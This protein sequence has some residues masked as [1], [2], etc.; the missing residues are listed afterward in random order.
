MLLAIL[1]YYPNVHQLIQIDFFMILL[2]YAVAS[3]SKYILSFETS[4]MTPIWA[5]R[6]VLASIPLPTN[7]P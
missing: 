6:E 2:Q 7:E 4:N 5:A 1:E 3:Q